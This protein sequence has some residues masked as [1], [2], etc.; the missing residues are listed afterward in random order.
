MAYI[1]SFPKIK[2]E[3]LGLGDIELEKCEDFLSESSFAESDFDLLM[4][5]NFFDVMKDI[6][7]VE[8][9]RSEQS[10]KMPKYDPSKQYDN[11][12]YNLFIQN[13]NLLEQVEIA[14][15]DRNDIISKIYRI[16]DFYDRNV[17]QM[18]ALRYRP[19]GRKIHVRK[20]MAMLERDQGCPYEGC[21]KKYASEGSLN[22]HIK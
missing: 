16:Q 11:E 9:P 18:K 20:T 7:D 14:A 1:K 10:M 22:L 15:E 2:L 13:Q 4:S 5:D 19:G 17:G 8:S 3:Q 21:D 12:F 6:E